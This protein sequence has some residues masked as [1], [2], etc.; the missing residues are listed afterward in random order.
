M[1]IQIS[2]EKGTY[3]RKLLTLLN[4]IPPF[5][6]VRPKELHLYA[7]LLEINHKY[8]KIPL[9]ERNKL[10]FNYDI[11][12]TLGEQ[13]KVKPSGIYNL[14]KGLRQAGIIEKDKLVPKYIIPREK[15]VIFIFEDE[16]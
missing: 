4:D 3:F 6:Q 1:N 12:T 8:R 9:P 5:N 15:K 2:V 10:I 7:L 13:L 11:R 14:M 16:G